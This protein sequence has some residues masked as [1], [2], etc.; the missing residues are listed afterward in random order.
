MFP[1]NENWFSWEWCG[2][3]CCGFTVLYTVGEIKHFSFY[4]FLIAWPN[5]F[6]EKVNDTAVA[7]DRVGE[8]EITP[9]SAA[10]ARH[11]GI[12][13]TTEGKAARNRRGLAIIVHG[14]PLSGHF[15]LLFSPL[16]F[17]VKSSYMWDINIRPFPV[18]F[19]SFIILC[20]L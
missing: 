15:L 13:L 9:V 1:G 4:L 2:E 17:Y 14:A 19:L 11:L 6:A 7:V 10:I 20:H 3:K 12:D 16:F 5:S 18:S 8:L